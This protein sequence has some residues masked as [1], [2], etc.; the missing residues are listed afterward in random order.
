MYVPERYRD[1]KTFERYF[2]EHFGPGVYRLNHV[3]PSGNNVYFVALPH[4]Q[5]EELDAWQDAL[6]DRHDGNV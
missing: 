3:A 4:V 5:Q 6:W 1:A 2:N